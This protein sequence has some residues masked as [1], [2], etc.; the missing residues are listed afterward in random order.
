MLLCNPVIFFLI[1][2]IYVLSVVGVKQGKGRVMWRRCI[3]CQAAE[4]DENENG[5]AKAKA[6]TNNV[7]GTLIYLDCI[8]CLLVYSYHAT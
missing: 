2:F 5:R 6:P 3:C 1:K 4:F 7:D 8:I